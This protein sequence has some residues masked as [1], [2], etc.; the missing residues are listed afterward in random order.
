MPALD[1]M[2]ILDMTQYEAG[3]SCTQALAWMGADVVKIERPGTGDPGRGLDMGLWQDTEYFVNWN[4]NK[5]SVAL[6]LT[7]PEGRD[8]L[9]RLLP[10][11]DVFVENYGPGVIEKLGLTYEVMR[12]KHPGLIYGRIK[13]FGT[14]GPYANYKSYDVVAQA[15]S[16]AMSITGEA[17]GGP[18]RLGP[19]IG[20]VGTGVQLGMAILAA[21]IQKMRTGEGQLIEISMQ[22]AVTYFMRTALSMGA[23]WGT[24]AARRR[25]NGTNPNVNL[26][27]CKGGGPNDYVFIMAVTDAMWEKVCRVIERPDL[28]E[29][30][31]FQG[32]AKRR[33]HCAELMAEVSKWTVERD[34]H[35]AMRTLADAGVPA[36]AIFDTKDLYTDPHLLERGFVHQVEHEELGTVPLLGWPA[37]MSASEV[38]IVAAPVLGRHTR[39]VLSGEL[40]ITDAEFALLEESGIVADAADQDAFRT[41]RTGSQA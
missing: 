15:S 32:G 35:E 28:L 40:G 13:G 33:E 19:T 26:Y 8:L 27:P 31:R 30:P 12:E 38:P 21:Y 37:R 20:D 29:D 34:K 36:S 18:L 17:D 10:R 14:T 5:R 25:G 16:G 6:D 41:G 23:Q 1:G 39:E 4:S 3:T 9:F 11:F 7:R 2:R 24:R 22:E